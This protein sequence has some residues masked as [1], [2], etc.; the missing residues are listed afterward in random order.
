MSFPETIVLTY[1][2][3]K[4]QTSVQKCPLGT[5]G[6]L[7]DG[8]VYRYSKSAAAITIGQ[9]CTATAPVGNYYATSGGVTPAATTFTTTWTYIQIQTSMQA[10]ATAETANTYA[11]GYLLDPTD[12]ALVRIKSHAGHTASST[13]QTKFYFEDGDH[14]PVNITGTDQCIMI[15]RNPYDGVKIAPATANAGAVALG[16]TNMNVSSGYYFWLQ[17]GGPGGAE[18]IGTVLAGEPVYHSTET[19]TS[20]TLFNTTDLRLSPNVGLMINPAATTLYG[21]IM[22]QLSP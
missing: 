15:I 20:F 14:L 22:V 12:G 17:T 10:D 3:V 19:A 21:M 13:E 1:G 5:R 6:V 7:P 8:R 11:E 2:E 4:T 16:Y 9:L 18:L